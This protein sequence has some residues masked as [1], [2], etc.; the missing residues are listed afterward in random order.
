M[1][2]P[3]GQRLIAGQNYIAAQRQQTAA[4]FVIM[5]VY[6]V[7]TFLIYNHFKTRFADSEEQTAKLESQVEVAFE[8]LRSARRAHEL[9]P[10]DEV[11][12]VAYWDAKSR[13]DYLLSRYER[14]KRQSYE[15]NDFAESMIDNGG[16]VGIQVGMWFLFAA[17]YLFLPMLTGSQPTRTSMM[18]SRTF[19][20]LLVS[21]ISNLS[22]WAT[23]FAIYQTADW[24]WSKSTQS[25]VGVLAVNARRSEDYS[26][27]A[28]AIR[29][30][31]WWITFCLAF[32]STITGLILLLSYRRFLSDTYRFASLATTM[33]V[34]GGGTF[35]GWT[36]INFLIA[37]PSNLDEPQCSILSQMETCPLDDNGWA[38]KVDP[39]SSEC[40]KMRNP[41]P[42]PDQTVPQQS[43]CPDPVELITIKNDY[44]VCRLGSWDKARASGEK[45]PHPSHKRRRDLQRQDLYLDEKAAA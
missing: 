33:A 25:W 6:G 5:C 17:K 4:T 38:S 15:G 45:D 34:F 26:P 24:A 21:L 2:M 16:V 43:Q 8:T 3:Y 1:Q 32:G 11:K 10:G 40:C 7:F 27:Q 37:L 30:D 13:Y 20:F 19:L 29:I 23:Y 31:N 14:L 28:R 35:G 18:N 36:L 9:A 12:S 22:M 44:E 39:K 42:N 41:N